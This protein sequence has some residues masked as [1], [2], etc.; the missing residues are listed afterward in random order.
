MSDPEVVDAPAVFLIDFGLGYHSED[1]ED[2]AMDLQVFRRSLTGTETDANRFVR[3]VE[4][5]YRETGNPA[6]LD[7]LR[8]I[9]SR[10]R[11]Q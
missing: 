10:G 6:V 4:S 3:E 1:P 8:D 7:C 5:A 11:Y 9:E 2:H